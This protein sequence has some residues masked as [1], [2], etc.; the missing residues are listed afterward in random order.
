MELVGI[1]KGCAIV[2]VPNSRIKIVMVHSATVCRLAGLVVVVIAMDQSGCSIPARF[3]EEMLGQV[4]E[5]ASKVVDGGTG[6]A[7]R[8][9]VVGPVDDERLADDVPSG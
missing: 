1:T 7:L 9:G 8:G 4:Q 3:S 2:E 6:Q 5:V